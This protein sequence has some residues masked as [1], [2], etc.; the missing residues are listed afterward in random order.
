MQAS[1]CRPQHA[2]LPST[3]HPAQGLSVWNQSN[4]V[5]V[6]DSLD[7]ADSE[8]YN[9]INVEEFT[10]DVGNTQDDVLG[11]ALAYIEDLAWESGVSSAI[12][13]RP[14]EGAHGQ[15]W[16]WRI[17]CPQSKAIKRGIRNRWRPSKSAESR[18]SQKPLGYVRS[19]YGTRVVGKL[20]EED[21][22]HG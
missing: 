16:N 7:K 15:Q 8:P 20:L 9:M 19:G 2:A 21:C 13:R 4:T 3:E 14:F 18:Q 6:D 5:L 12:H 22:S 1:A 10:G 11:A 17:G